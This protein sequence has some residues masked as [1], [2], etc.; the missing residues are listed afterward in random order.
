MI[1]VVGLVRGFRIIRVFGTRPF[2]FWWLMSRMS[3]IIVQAM[4]IS[5][6]IL[7]LIRGSHVHLLF[8]PTL[9]VLARLGN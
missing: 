6:L 4:V 3:T 8:L 9:I 5:E 2:Y 1:P 7:Y